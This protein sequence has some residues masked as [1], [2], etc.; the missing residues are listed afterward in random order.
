MQH[1]LTFFDEREIVTTASGLIIG[2]I[3]RE[4]R[5]VTKQEGAAGAV[6]D[7][8]HVARSISRPDVFDLADD[9]QL[10][11]PASPKNVPIPLNLGTVCAGKSL[12]GI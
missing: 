1:S 10:A 5:I 12:L 3:N 6:A 9:A 2:S 7:E 8:E 4:T 11:E